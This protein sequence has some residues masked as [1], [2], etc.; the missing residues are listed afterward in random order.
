MVH[1]IR[2]HLGVGEEEA[3]GIRQEYWQRYGAT[4]LGLMRH[5]GTDPQH[6]LRETHRF[7]DLRS[8][9]VVERGV[10]AMLDR[11]PGRKLIFSN[12][13][14]HYTEAVLELGG[15]RTCFD[16]VYSVERLRFLPK[17]AIGGYRRLLAEEGLAGTDCILVEDAA[18]NLRTAKQLGMKT[19]WVS[20]STRRP[21]FVDVRVVSVLDLPGRLSRLG[22]RVP[23]GPR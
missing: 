1:Y 11:L 14:L 2:S 3:I 21:P 13:P 23:R 4:L 16:S 5:H 17:P 8:M 9:L 15:I 19:V 7:A 18:S 6:F 10:K 22:A 12:A 20:R